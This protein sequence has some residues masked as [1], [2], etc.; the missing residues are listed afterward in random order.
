MR[1]SV[2]GFSIGV[3]LMN[4]TVSRRG[5]RVVLLLVFPPFTGVE[6]RDIIKE[7]LLMEDERH[8][9]FYWMSPRVLSRG[10]GFTKV[11]IQLTPSRDSKH[12]GAGQFFEAGFV[13]I[14]N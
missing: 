13:K 14:I 10:T 4:P 7:R 12:S 8:K 2:W 11:L 3:W 6:Q 1:C 9:A 5:R